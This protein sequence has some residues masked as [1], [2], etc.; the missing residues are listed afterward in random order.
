MPVGGALALKMEQ[1]I[2]D[3]EHRVR[4]ECARDLDIVFP[5][6][7]DFRILRDLLRKNLVDQRNE[8]LRISLG[9]GSERV[10]KNCAAFRLRR[11]QFLLP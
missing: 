7:Y 3:P 5:P 4:D 11:C 9:H 10:I 6:F 1:P 2:P 8:K